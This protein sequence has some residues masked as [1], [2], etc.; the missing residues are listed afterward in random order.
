MRDSERTN[1]SCP[2]R[3]LLATSNT[4][5]EPFDV[6]ISFRFQD[7]HQD[8]KA[9]QKALEKRKLS[10]FVSEDMVPPGQN[11]QIQ[12]ARALAN[13]RVAVI[14]ASKTY[15]TRMNGLFDTLRELN[16]IITEK[17]PYT[18]WCA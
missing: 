6:F 4:A 2:I 1:C 18:T 15:G 5:E 14:L 9:L 17:K 16:F 13:C 12:I 11:L 10:V 3:R 8:A 7:T